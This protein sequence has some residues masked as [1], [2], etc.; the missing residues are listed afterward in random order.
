MQPLQKLT[1]T[2]T[3]AR[4]QV[5]SV[6]GAARQQ[7]RQ[8][9]DQ[10]LS[11]V[12]QASQA[13]S[14]LNIRAVGDQIAPYAQF[15]DDVAGTFSQVQ[16]QV[17]SAAHVADKV[18]SWKSEAQQSANDLLD[19]V[20]QAAEQAQ[21]GASEVQTAADNTASGAQSAGEAIVDSPV[22]EQVQASFD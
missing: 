4:G 3:S 20:Q 15:Y 14:G 10:A 17:Q 6:S 8:A 1:D 7:V 11:Y 13:I 19:R 16:S 5:D 12:D 21:Q 22:S 18:N 9:A 2:L